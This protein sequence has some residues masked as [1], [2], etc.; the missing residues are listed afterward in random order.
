[1][2]EKKDAG[3]KNAPLLLLMLALTPLY[4]GYH[5]F[6]VFL[7][8][9]AIV[10]LLYAAWRRGGMVLPC[11]VEAWCLYGI[12]ACMVLTGIFSS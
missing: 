12:W 6:S 5:N 2:A 7:A 3:R 10:P 9:L 11:G 1:M 4:G 8:G